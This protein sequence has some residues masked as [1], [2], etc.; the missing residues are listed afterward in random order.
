MLL[1]VLLVVLVVL[2][3]KLATMLVCVLSPCFSMSSK[4]R[5]VFADD[6]S[7]CL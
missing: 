7:G 2:F 3:P 4:L 5:S 6:L 1:T